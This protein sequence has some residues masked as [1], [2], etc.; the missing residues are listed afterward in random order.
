M[1]VYGVVLAGGA[2]ERMRGVNKANLLLDGEPLLSICADFAGKQVDEVF[3]SASAETAPLVR[4][5]ADV[6]EDKYPRQGPLAAVLNCLQWI[7]QRHG[8]S[9]VAFFPCDAPIFPPDLVRQLTDA[10]EPGRPTYP[11][12]NAN[13]LYAFSLWPSSCAPALLDFFNSGNRSLNS[14]LHQFKAKSLIISDNQR[15]KRC[16]FNI[17]TKEDWKNFL[18]MT[19]GKSKSN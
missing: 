17:N 11:I 5:A 8:E 16:F 9:L 15:D 2:S 3:I 10:A 18:E 1:K 6:I 12:Y 13:K 19:E 14:A 4:N 7:N